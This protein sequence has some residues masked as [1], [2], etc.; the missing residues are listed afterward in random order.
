MGVDY[1]DRLFYDSIRYLSKTKDTTGRT[2]ESKYSFLKEERNV[3]KPTSQFFLTNGRGFESLCYRLDIFN[4]EE[5]AC[6]FDS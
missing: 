6:Q 3:T 2:R 1:D 4:R 5:A